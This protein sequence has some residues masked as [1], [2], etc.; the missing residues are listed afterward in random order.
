METAISVE[1][2]NKI[3]KL[4]DRQRDRVRDALGLTKKQLYHEH[5]ALKDVSI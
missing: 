4:Y 5:Y 3:Y 2:L 1:H